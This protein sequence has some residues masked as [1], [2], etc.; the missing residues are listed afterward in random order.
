MMKDIESEVILLGRALRTSPAACAGRAWGG[1]RR[2][3]KRWPGRWWVM[4][5]RR[6]AWRSCSSTGP[7]SDAAPPVCFSLTP[8]EQRTGRSPHHH[9]Q[10]VTVSYYLVALH[11]TCVLLHHVSC[12]LMTRDPKCLLLLLCLVFLYPL[13][14]DSYA[15]VCVRLESQ[16]YYLCD[17]SCMDH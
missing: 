10:M 14:Q 9:H 2:T 6:R 17:V 12:N 11:R 15:A 7:S 1:R 13:D 16:Y 4:T 5:V 3:S 8:P